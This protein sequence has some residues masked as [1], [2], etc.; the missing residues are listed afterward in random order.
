MRKY[1]SIS[2]HNSATE[3]YC[4]MVIRKQSSQQSFKLDASFKFDRDLMPNPPSDIRQ[5][6]V[7]CY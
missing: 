2:P 1:I 7:F 3:Q 4:P 5:S 6:Q